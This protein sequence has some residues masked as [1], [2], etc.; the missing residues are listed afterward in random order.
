MSQPPL[1]PVEILTFGPARVGPGADG[2]SR[3]LALRAF[4][5]VLERIAPVRVL[6]RP[7]SQLDYRVRDARQRGRQPVVLAFRPFQD[8]FLIRGVPILNYCLWEYPDIPAE[9]LHD[10]PRY[11]W[12]RMAG[13]V[14]MVLCG[15]SATAEAFRR[16]GVT[17]PLL[18]VPPPLPPRWFALP[19]RPGAS[20]LP[21]V[22]LSA[23][24]RLPPD[25]SSAC[26]AGG[27]A[28]GRRGA[29]AFKYRLEVAARRFAPSF[30]Y[31]LACATHR[32]LCRARTKAPTP[33]AGGDEPPFPGREWP[34]GHVVFTFVFDPADR[35]H[36][37]RELL[38][39]FVLTLAD[40]G[41]TTLLLRPTCPPAR[42]GWCLGEARRLYRTLAHL[43]P[44][45]R[46]LVVDPR[47]PDEA[48]GRLIAT[49]TWY[50]NASRA[51][52]CCRP[53]LQAMAAGRPALSPT[54][55]DM[56]DYCS[57]RSGIVLDSEEEPTHWPGD[58]TGRLTTSWHRLSWPSLCR[59]LREAY[60]IARCRPEVYAE[61][62]EGARQAARARAPEEAVEAL[63]R[64]AIAAACRR[65]APLA[66]EV[67]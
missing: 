15:S 65:G 44:R 35:H 46:A 42:T 16:A 25:E 8:A 23:G 41:D 49:T 21:A 5:P 59:G 3:G 60:H 63:L 22:E 66:R 29:G 1:P 32:W 27:V 55:T 54:H 40:R 38:A 20:G 33:S 13:Q 62:A 64:Q 48:M 14:A 45:C 30:L 4:L 6:A 28:P 39:A 61:L 17:T 51:E 10:N 34:E 47:L 9:A 67:A 57:A 58:E 26:A 31:K 43:R 11:D 37:W 36:A 12:R 7:E 18:V 52:A 2:C 53:L 24:P 56:A 19:A 50:V